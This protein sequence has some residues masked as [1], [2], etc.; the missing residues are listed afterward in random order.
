M[1]SRTIYYTPLIDIMSTWAGT[2][3]KRAVEIWQLIHVRNGQGTLELRIHLPF[4]V[5]P[6]QTDHR[7]VNPRLLLLCPP[8]RA[9][10]PPYQSSSPLLSRVDASGGMSCSHSSTGL[11]AGHYTIY[12]LVEGGRKK[13]TNNPPPSFLEI[14]GNLESGLPTLGSLS[15]PLLWDLGYARL[16]GCSDYRLYGKHQSIRVHSH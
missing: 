1:Y 8:P 5:D 4:Q 12:R 15:P 14:P 10:A 13:E 6:E 11:P 2:S 16:L 7:F 3:A 9:P